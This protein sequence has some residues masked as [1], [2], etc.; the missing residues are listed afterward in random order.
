MARS[1]LATRFGV[2]AEE[3]PG[4]RVETADW[5]SNETQGQVRE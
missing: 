2:Q 4:F 3:L 1:A 5:I